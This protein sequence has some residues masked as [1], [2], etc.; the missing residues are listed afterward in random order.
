MKTALDVTQSI[1]DRAKKFSEEGNDCLVGI[2]LDLH[3]KL[4]D[5]IIKES[6]D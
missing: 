1:L 4:L 2:Y 6:K 3:S 5:E